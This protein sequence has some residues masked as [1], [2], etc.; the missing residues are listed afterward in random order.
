MVKNLVA[1]AGNIRDLG[2]DPW[3]RNIPWRRKW[4]PTPVFLPEKAHGKR[5]LVG[6]NPSI[7]DL[8][9]TER[10]SMHTQETK[11]PQAANVA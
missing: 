3:V 10:L 9:T 11:I 2:F 5:S 4:H 6:Y 8:D 1:N 7:T